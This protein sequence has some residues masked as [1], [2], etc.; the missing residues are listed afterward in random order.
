M[1]TQRLHEIL[2]LTTIQLRKEKEMVTTEQVGS[3]N[4]T[5]INAMP[6]EDEVTKYEKVDLE[7]LVIGV[8]HN[9]A[10]KYKDELIKILKKYPEPKRL[11][12]GPSYIEVGAIIG[13]QGAAFQLFALGKVLGLWEVITPATLGFSGKEATDLA[14]KGFIMIS[15]FKV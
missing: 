3:L 12:A 11:A 1:N 7:F 2:R 4:V 14:G 5:T 10:T 8:D 15:G 13:D 9:L 6:H